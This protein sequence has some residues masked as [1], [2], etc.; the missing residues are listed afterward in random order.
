[1]TELLVSV[2]VTITAGH[3]AFQQVKSMMAVSCMMVDGMSRLFVV[4]L[5][6]I[7]LSMHAPL[8]VTSH[9]LTLS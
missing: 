3:P 9:Q 7:S 4:S 1:M 6:R 8:K 2:W 5:S